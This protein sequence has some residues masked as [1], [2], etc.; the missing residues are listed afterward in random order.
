MLLGLVILIWGCNWPIMKIAMGEQLIAPFTFA[1]VR[2]VLAAL[3]MF[4][5]AALAGQLRLPSRHDWPVV[6]SIGLVQMG[7]F[8]GLVNYALQYVPAGRSAILTYTTPI[9]IVPMAIIILGE[10]V[11]F[12]KWIGFILGLIGILIM[13]NPA[14]FD[15]SNPDTLKGNGILLFTAFLWSVLMIHIKG[16]QWQGTPLS[17]APWQFVIAMLILLPAVFYLETDKQIILSGKTALIMLYNGPLATAFCFWAMIT[18]TRTLPAINTSLGMLGVPVIGVIG[19]ALVLGESISPNN[20]VGLLVITVGL[21][22]LILA[23][24]RKLG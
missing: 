7:T 1:L 24:L 4:I 21:T 17:L 12:L 16:H 13:F 6:L 22:V 19:A 5:A 3:V 23:D 10:K 11:S 2:V 18:V 9:W 8:M 20:L 15:W 14:A